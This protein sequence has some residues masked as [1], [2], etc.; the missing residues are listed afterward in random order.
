MIH[1]YNKEYCCVACYVYIL[2]LYTVYTTIT[3]C[4][5][6]SKTWA[7][8]FSFNPNTGVTMYIATEFYSTRATRAHGALCEYLSMGNNRYLSQHAVCHIVVVH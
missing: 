1:L 2:N 7:V 8:P 4:V 5:T 3:R 6:A